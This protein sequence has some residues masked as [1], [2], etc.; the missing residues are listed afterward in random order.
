MSGPPRDVLVVVNPASR[1]GQRAGRRAV[2]AL[3][4]A[5]VRCTTVYT[6]RPGHARVLAA[7]QGRAHDAV[8]A[9]GGDGTIMEIVS[10]LAPDGPPVAII[11]AGTGNLLARAL[12]VP[13]SPE[14]AVRMLLDASEARIDLG[15]LADGTRVAIGAGVGIDAAMIATT[16]STWKRRVGVIAYVVTGARHALVRRRFSA[17]ITVDGVAV[18]RTASSVLVANFGALLNGLI[19]LGDGIRYDDGMLDVCIFD[20][21]NTLDAARIA[22]RLLTGRAGSDP[23]MAYLRGREIVVSTEPPLPAQAD[24]E[25]IGATPFAV[26][27]EP[28]AARLLIPHSERSRRAR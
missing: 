16:S 2:A 12:G 8:C 17:T 19:T 23:A 22:L 6:E 26:T 9:V 28:L 27:V 25:L 5:G 24:G 1:R 7:E 18:T 15:R 3:E 10:A 20:P 4:R 21:R 11:P 13:L 14:R